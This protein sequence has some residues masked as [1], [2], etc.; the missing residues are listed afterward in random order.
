MPLPVVTKLRL[1][2]PNAKLFDPVVFADKALNPIAT[3]PTCCVNLPAFVPI[4]IVPYCCPVKPAL[5]PI[6]MALA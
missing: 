6:A 2:L 3:P 4:E 1:K 5:E